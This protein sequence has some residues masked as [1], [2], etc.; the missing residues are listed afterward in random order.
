LR[1]WLNVPS[2]GDTSQPQAKG[3]ADVTAD[4]DVR[5]N[6]AVIV[7]KAGIDKPLVVVVR[8][9]VAAGPK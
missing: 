4:I 7:A 8:A 6:E 2:T 3:S 9:G 1:V 5:Q